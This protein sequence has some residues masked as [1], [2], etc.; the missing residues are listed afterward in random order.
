M[1]KVITKKLRALLSRGA[2]AQLKSSDTEPLH[3]VQA[4]AMHA[5]HYRIVIILCVDLCLLSAAMAQ[6]ILPPCP[7]E[8]GA[9]KT[10]CV[11]IAITS[12]A[13]YE[14]EYKNNKQSGF[15]KV[16]FT[17]GQKY[18][19][20]V[21]NGVLHGYGTTT[22]PDGAAYYGTFVNGEAD[23]Y[24]AFIEENGRY[25]IWHFT[26]GNQDGNGTYY[27]ND[28]IVI[29]T[30][31]WRKGAFV[32]SLP[33][34]VAEA[35]EIGNDA[36]LGAMCAGPTRPA[37]CQ[38]VKVF[39]QVRAKAARINLPVLGY[40]AAQGQLCQGPFG[41]GACMDVKL[42][43]ATQQIAQQE[44]DLNIIDYVP[45]VGSIC[46]GPAGPGPCDA[47]KVYLLQNQ[48]G[49]PP[50]ASPDLRQVQ[51][52]SRSSD[53][54]GPFCV[55]PFGPMPC[56]MLAQ[57]GLDQ[58][59]GTVQAQSDF[60]LPSEV[61][62]VQEL[63]VECAKRVGIDVVGFSGCTGLHMVMTEAQQDMLDCAATSRTAENFANCAA[64]KVGINL[65]DNQKLI[66]GCAIQSKGDAGDFVTC[67][68]GEF[69]NRTLSGDEQ[70][71]LKCVK[72]A[73]GANS[74]FVSCSADHFLSSSKNAVVKCAISA[75]DVGSFTKCAAPNLGV[76][77]TEEQ[78]TL[79]R[80]AMTSGGDAHDFGTCA[81][82]AFLGMALGPNEQAVLDC[83]RNASGDYGKFAACSASKI[84][85]GN[86]SKEQRVALECTAQSY[87]DPTGI[88]TCAGANM[89]NLQLNPEQQ[90]A[91][92]CV[93][94]TGG[95]P[96]AAAGCMATRLTFR[97]LTKCLT[98]GVGG[99]GCFGDN[100]DL[101][102][103]NG[104]LRRTVGQIAGGK[105][106]V[107][108]NLDQVCGGDNSFVRNPHQMFGGNNS[109]IRHP[110]QF[111]GGK[112]SV[113]NKAG[114][115]LSSPKPL[116][117]GTVGGKRICLPWC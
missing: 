33:N 53:T 73:K 86:M 91:V 104:W 60:G 117:I 92:Q 20:A 65:P 43:L 1:P 34:F 15:A 94:S 69:L 113:F 112:N 48:I 116:P 32:R 97:E 38:V 110:S 107:I 42:Y 25:Y 6:S 108:N 67:A 55:G 58:F 87:G 99:R 28:G 27:T 83:A 40:D 59:Q 105:N 26:R 56:T 36:S 13:R 12:W 31:I 62:S 7:D 11:G 66:A 76:Q 70:A 57:A 3:M 72:D 35:Q 71:I 75:G 5:K 103:K 37:P 77:M 93:V 81:G 9:Y 84:L 63:A 14:G 39:L 68:G 22:W 111:W 100:N 45:G 85:G 16:Y 23:G 98:D 41:P 115:L 46:A 88:A 90:I 114:Q 8:V 96:Y 50:I 2:G 80:C 54:I 49:T 82:T 19:G 106:S 78:R 44:V 64:P 4:K 109:F 18:V 30:G 47:I 29:E 101:V 51:L 79:A 17:N 102:G 24:G 89:F 95:Q 74:D 21:Y 52:L 10:N 61:H